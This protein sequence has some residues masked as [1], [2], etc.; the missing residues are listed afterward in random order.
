MIGYTD[1]R[2]SRVAERIGGNFRRLFISD[3]SNGDFEFDHASQP[4]YIYIGKED[5]EEPAGQLS[6]LVDAHFWKDVRT[7]I[8]FYRIGNR[9]VKRLFRSLEIYPPYLPRSDRPRDRS[10]EAG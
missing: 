10:A 7:T 3:R 8:L 4:D 5:P 9:R 6:S 2:H 1:C